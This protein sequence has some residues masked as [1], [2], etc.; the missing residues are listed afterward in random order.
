[1]S[2][3]FERRATEFLRD[4]E[5]FLSVVTPEPLVTF[6]ESPA[7]DGSLYEKLT[8]VVGNPG[9]GKTTL[10]RLYEFKTLATLLRNQGL[11]TYRPLLQAMTDCGA[12]EAGRPNIIGCRIPLESEYRDFWEFPYAPELKLNLMGALLQS[13]AVLAWF[14]NLAAAGVLASDVTVNARANAVAAADEIGGTDGVSVVDRARKIERALYRVSAA[15]IPPDESEITEVAASPYR[16]FDVIESFTIEFDGARLT[17]PVLAVFDDAHSLHPDQLDG[18]TRWLARRE[19][20]VAR[21]IVTRLDALTPTQVLIEPSDSPGITIGRDVLPIRMQSTQ[22]GSQTRVPFR[23]M[24]KDMASRYLQ[25]MDVFQRRSI[26]D[27]ADILSTKVPRPP[28]TRIDEGV[29][30]SRQLAKR[31]GITDATYA[32]LDA[33]VRRYFEGSRMEGGPELEAACLQI[34][35][36]RYVRRNAALSLLVDFEED[37][38]NPSEKIPAMS[39]SVAEGARMHLLHRVGRPVFFGLDAVSDASSENAELFL[40]LCGRLAA[41]SETQLVRGKN[42]TISAETQNRLLRERAETIMA[43]WDFPRASEVRRLAS[44]LAASCLA[45]TLEPNAPLGAGAS[46]YG[47]PED[48]FLAIAQDF[49]ELAEVLKYGVAYTAFEITSSD[50]KNKRWR[51]LQLGGP[52]LLQFGLTIRRGGFIEGTAAGLAELIGRS[53]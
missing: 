4:D 50:A 25:Q 36:H 17:L 10:A 1:M 12:V 20:R 47:I 11:S 46:A 7:R 44:S 13:R 8:L 43:E 9:S 29:R 2:N 27:L 21:W 22:G 24:A 48:Q 26:R 16:P 30:A 31:L 23:R 32:V 38:P 14:R 37:E 41:Q 18:L 45:R 40:R 51:L 35:L 6:L 52:V 49:P 28:A 15:L 53:E 3:P 19:L 39:S 5:A 34:L 33:E 42:A